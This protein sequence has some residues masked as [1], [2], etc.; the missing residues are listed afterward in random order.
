MEIFGELEPLIFDPL[1][2]D[3]GQDGVSS[4]SPAKN[5]GPNAYLGDNVA[6][7]CLIDH[8]KSGFEGQLVYIWQGMF[9]GRL[10]H[11]N[12]MS[13]TLARVHLDS[14]K[15]LDVTTDCLVAFVSSV[16]HVASLI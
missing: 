14:S 11:V 3:D 16:S 9:K 10:G 15:V 6:K 7:R 1:T 8:F 4:K 5:E 12:R 2:D 13:G